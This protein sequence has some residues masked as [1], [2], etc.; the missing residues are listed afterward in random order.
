MIMTGWVTEYKTTAGSDID[1]LLETVNAMI[2]AKWQPL[3]GPLI[4]GG[5]IVQA[6]VKIDY[7]QDDQIAYD[8]AELNRKTNH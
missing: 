3:G 7:S 2:A 6:M 4:S 8:I 5:V 1:M